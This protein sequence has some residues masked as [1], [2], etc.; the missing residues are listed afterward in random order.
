M[1]T[2]PNYEEA[3][4]ANPKASIIRRVREGVWIAFREGCDAI[5]HPSTNHAVEKV[6]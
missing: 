4:A 5:G 3:R 2:Y 1:P 6:S